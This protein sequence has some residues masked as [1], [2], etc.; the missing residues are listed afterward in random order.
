MGKTLNMVQRALNL[1]D[2]GASSLQPP[3]PPLSDSEFRKFLDPVGQIMHSK[4]LRSV[5]YFGGIDS[6]LRCLVK[7]R[8]FFVSF[9]FVLFSLPC[10]HVCHVMIFV[11]PT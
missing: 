7:L 3:R 8:C 11:L 4:E 6:S 2:D 5:I 1:G 10:S 9:R